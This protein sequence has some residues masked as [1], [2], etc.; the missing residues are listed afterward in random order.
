MR[1]TASPLVLAPVRDE[2]P[3]SR[4]FS[5]VTTSLGAICLLVSCGG[6]GGGGGSGTAT[7]QALNI[8]EEP[9][10]TTSDNPTAPLVANLSVKTEEP[11][12]VTLSVEE[13]GQTWTLD[14][15]S[16]FSLEHQVPLLGLKPGKRHR[17]N[18]TLEGNNG[19]PDVTRTVLYDAPGLPDG[20]PPIQ[21]LTADADQSE[22]GLVL[23]SAQGTDT[24][25]GL[26]NRDY[27]VMLDKLGEV[28]WY[29]HDPNFFPSL[30]FPSENTTL[31][32]SDG[33][34]TREVD[35]LGNVLTSWAAD[36]HFPVSAPG[37]VR[38][39][40]DSFHHEFREL[41]DDPD[42]DLLTLSS[43][44][45]AYP[46]Y[47]IDEVDTN[48]TRDR[49]FVVGDIIAEI[50]RDGRVV[51]Q[52]SIL[53]ILDPYRVIYE[54]LVGFWN[55][56]YSLTTHDWSHGN[57]VMIDPSDNAY[58]MSLRNQ[59][60]VIKVDRETGEL[61][62]ILGDH[63]RWGPQH[64]PYLL[65][66]MGADFE[67][68]FYQHATSVLAD[69]SIVMFDNGNYRG[70]IPPMAPPPEEEWTSRIVAYKVDRQAMTVE[71]A[72]DFEDTTDPF[73]CATLGDVEYQ[74]ATGNLMICNG[75]M[76]N[77]FGTRSACLF[78]VDP[79]T[80]DKV[81]EVLIEAPQGEDSWTVYR[82]R[83]FSLVPWVTP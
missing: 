70:A 13:P 73:F 31:F 8:V 74:P 30:A 35:L 44:V 75:A 81:L 20:F 47:P 29:Y 57:S 66:P 17:I 11:S 40:L 82:A 14:S 60:A 27:V 63:R 58:V 42:A 56:V 48:L 78:E 24:G 62:W 34:V 1:I 61:V 51:R 2:I 23:L 72:W 46:D 52:R 38:V 79:A 43:E 69:G 65:T 64:Q 10:V 53:D 67:W 76:L 77:A 83:T 68:Q 21:V 4:A 25:S 41:R 71:E 3:M 33:I 59:S 36:R 54:S 12:R 15:G 19:A 28:V 6:G 50:T 32:L 39:D 55:G 5:P 45:R 16:G 49:G 26:G 9:I 80:G 7:P 18:I 22:P 37:A